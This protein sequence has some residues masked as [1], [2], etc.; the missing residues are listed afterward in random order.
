LHYGFNVVD[1]SRLLLDS[2]VLRLKKWFFK[3]AAHNKLGL[4]PRARFQ[5][6]HPQSHLLATIYLLYVN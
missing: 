4:F 5:H 3:D 2:L 1:Q 6:Q